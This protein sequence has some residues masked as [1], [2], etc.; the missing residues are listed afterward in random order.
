MAWHKKRKGAP[1]KAPFPIT[2]VIHRLDKPFHNKGNL[3][4][5]Q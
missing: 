2:I 3:G 4:V 1:N 5:F